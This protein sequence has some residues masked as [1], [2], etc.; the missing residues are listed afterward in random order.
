MPFLKRWFFPIVG[1]TLIFIMS[2]TP[3]TQVNSMG[4]E[5]ETFRMNG[6]FIMFFILCFLYYKST[7]N[8]FKSIL[9]T[10]IYAVLDELHQKITPYRSSSLFDVGIDI[11]GACLAG[12]ILWKLL[13]LLPKPLKNWLKK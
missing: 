4:F 9:F 6:H 2:S 8:I 13:Y 7:K 10:A 3:G 11:M 1:M 12:L 5:N